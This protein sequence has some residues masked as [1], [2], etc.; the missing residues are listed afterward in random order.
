VAKQIC[1]WIIAREE[2]WL[3]TIN[4]TVSIYEQ[5]LKE[6]STNWKL[7]SSF[8]WLST[9][10]KD[11]K[12]V[13]KYVWRHLWSVFNW[14]NENMNFFFQRLFCGYFWIIF[15]TASRKINRRF[16]TLIDLLAWI[17][18]YI[19]NLVYKWQFFSDN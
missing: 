18:S 10:I 14:L 11:C 2:I 19:I 3:S 7:K 16:R 12:I 6:V 8:I 15:K 4:F 5:L 17:Q 9:P 1:R 13:K